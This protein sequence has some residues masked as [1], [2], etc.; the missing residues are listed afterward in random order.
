MVLKKEHSNLLEL[1]GFSLKYCPRSRSSGTNI[2]DG[3]QVVKASCSVGANYREA[4]ESLIL[5]KSK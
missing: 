2:E 1:L 4:N 3:K 5:E